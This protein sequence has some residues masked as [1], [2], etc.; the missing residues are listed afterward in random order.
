M[1][2]KFTKEFIAEVKKEPRR[3]KD[4]EF[5]LAHEGKEI[6]LGNTQV[7][8]NGLLYDADRLEIVE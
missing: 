6:D 5:I 1:K 2:V 3:Y 4:T 7:K 8:I